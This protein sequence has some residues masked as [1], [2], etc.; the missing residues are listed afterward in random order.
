MGMDPG[1][2]TEL[3]AEHGARLLF[4]ATG[5]STAGRGGRARAAGTRSL[6]SRARQGASAGHAQVTPPRGWNGNQVCRGRSNSRL[7]EHL[8]D[9][10]SA[11]P[12]SGPALRAAEPGPSHPG[13]G[14]SAGAWSSSGISGLPD[15]AL[16]L[17]S[18]KLA[19]ARLP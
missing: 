16:R 3:A 8:W 11:G 1:R 9:C 18:G 14:A 13:G 4:I 12:A 15:T 2:T 7:L 5:R 6:D 19:R 17:R 10:S